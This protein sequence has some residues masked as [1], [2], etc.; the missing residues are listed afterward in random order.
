MLAIL[1]FCM[2]FASFLCPCLAFS[3]ICA[4]IY[5][6]SQSYKQLYILFALLSFLP[7]LFYGLIQSPLNNH[8]DGC[9]ILQVQTLPPLGHFSGFQMVT[10]TD[11]TQIFFWVWI[12][13]QPF[14]FFMNMDTVNSER[15]EVFL[16]DPYRF[17]VVRIITC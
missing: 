13:W 1:S 16:D 11:D 9:I 15:C 3:H 14:F 12:M 6:F 10:I 17:R 2:A 5:S 4:Y 8:S 7:Y